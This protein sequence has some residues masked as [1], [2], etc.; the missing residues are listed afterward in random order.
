[1][2]QKRNSSS[3]LPPLM[4]LPVFFVL[5]GISKS[6][7]YKLPPEQRPRIVNVGCKP[8]IRDVDALDWVA[9]LPEREA[10]A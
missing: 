1:M 8:M 6:L 10:A 3:A 5:F 9:N 4:P 7:F 2:L